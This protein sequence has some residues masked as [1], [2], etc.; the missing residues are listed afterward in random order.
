MSKYSGV[1]Y[2]EDSNQTDFRVIYIVTK[3]PD[4][5]IKIPTFKVNE[6]NKTEFIKQ[7]RTT[8]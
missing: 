3:N 7:I 8:N 1:L 6:T 2:I 5:F 4:N